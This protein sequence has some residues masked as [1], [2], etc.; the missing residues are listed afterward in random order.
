MELPS[1]MLSISWL[2]FVFVPGLMLRGEFLLPYP[3]ECDAEEVNADWFYTLL[4]FPLWT[5]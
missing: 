3:S 1:T 5:F 2:L 4:A